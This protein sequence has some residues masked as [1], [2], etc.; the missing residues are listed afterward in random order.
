MH[1]LFQ[2]LGKIQ[3][4]LLKKKF[5]HF[6]DGS[7]I[8]PFLNSANEK[9]ISIGDNVNI[10]SNCRITVSTEFGGHK[11]KSDNKIRIKIGDNVDIGN[12]TFISANN[13]VEIGNHVI[14]SSYVFITDHDHGFQDFSRNLHEQP[15]TEG[16]FVK[17]GNNVFL[18]TKCSILKNVTIGE[19]SVVAANA[20]VTKD[21][22][23]C[24]IV[25][26]NPARLIK[27]FDFEQNKWTKPQ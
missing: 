9:Y 23:A 19:R 3:T 6:G 26:G 10:G 25:A 14:I 11:V 12:N 18:G 1:K 22:P 16:S 21:V 7:I 24:S 13:S 20:V 2:I 27:K 5:H 17:I 15:L 4:F 8:K